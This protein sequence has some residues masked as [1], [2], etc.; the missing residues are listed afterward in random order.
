MIL[1]PL[2]SVVFAL[3]IDF[4]LGDPKNKFHPTVWVGALIGKLVP[5]FK[6][7]DPTTER[8]GGLILTISITTLVASILY[9]L[10]IALHYLNQFDF[11]FT[12]N[13]VTLIFSII[14]I[15]FLLIFTISINVIEILSKLI[16]I[17]FL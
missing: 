15:G 7:H 3:S 11:D 14:F 9:F 10:N 1:I 4:A 8:L 17:V 16:M 2:L 13:I 12:T 5:F 6:N